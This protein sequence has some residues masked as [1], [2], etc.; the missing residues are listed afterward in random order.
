MK[1]NHDSN[2]LSPNSFAQRAPKVWGLLTKKLKDTLEETTARQRLSDLFHTLATKQLLEHPGIKREAGVSFNPRPARHIEI[3]LRETANSDPHIWL[4][5]LMTILLE[6]DSTALLEQSELRPARDTALMVLQFERAPGLE[7]IDDRI[8]T[9]LLSR[10]L[11]NLRHAHMADQAVFSLD[12]TLLIADALLTIC[13]DKTATG[14][15][16]LLVG[17]AVERIK[18]RVKR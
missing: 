9:I 15:L 18:L 1:S 11:D 6:H 13:R 17:S 14:T 7:S 10:S 16:P 12:Q 3:I 5:S 2:E 4:T 8:A